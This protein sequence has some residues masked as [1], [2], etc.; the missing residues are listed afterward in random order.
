MSDE[1]APASNSETGRWLVL[2]TL[3]IISIAAYF[4]VADQVPVVVQ[5]PATSADP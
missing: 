2:L 1:N 5:S 4:S 3:L